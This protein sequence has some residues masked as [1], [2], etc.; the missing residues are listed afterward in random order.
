MILGSSVT[1]VYSKRQLDVQS[2]LLRVSKNKFVFLPWK[3][4]H[5]KSPPITLSIGNYVFSGGNSRRDYQTLFEAVRGTGIPVIVSATDSRVYAHPDIP[6]NVVLLAA[7]EPAFARLMAGSRF[8]VV[9]IMPGLVRGAGD[10]TVCDA[11]WHG[12]PVICADNISAFEYVEDG[13]T[14]YVTPPGDVASLRKR[15]LELWNQPDKAIQMGLAA[16]QGI[17][18]NCTHEHFVRRLRALGALVAAASD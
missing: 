18:A 14:G 3:S 9:P 7:Q 17:A 16:H 12:R 11:M 1:I 8:V 4:N 15:I 5:S 6:E 10:T 2:N 13:I